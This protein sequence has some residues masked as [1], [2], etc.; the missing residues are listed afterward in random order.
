MLVGLLCGSER[1][2]PPAFIDRVNELG[3][4][5]GIH[6]EMLALGGTWIGEPP[7]YSV[8]ID[9]ISQKIAYYR[10][11]LK[12]ALLQGTYVINN[13]FWSTA[14]DRF[15]DS[16]IAQKLGL[17]VPRTVLLPQKSYPHDAGIGL[18]WDTLLEYVGRPALL[19]TCS[20]AGWDHTFKVHNLEELL[21][22]YDITG[23]YCVML[24]EFIDYEK[25][26]RCF[27]FGK[28]E[29]IP[30]AYDPATRQNQVIHDYLD[31]Q[32]GA[33]VVK[34]AQTINEA[35][36]YEM[37]SIDFAIKDGIPYA[38]DLANA[39]PE[40]ERER[41]TEF[42]FTHIVDRMARLVIDR[43]LNGSIANTWPRWREMAGLEETGDNTAPPASHAATSA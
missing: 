31:S 25:Y 27:T 2:F 6:A 3:K 4:K 43:A 21:A 42:Y 37:N 14:D 40:F 19:K 15:F 10:N 22:A 38:V 32:L 13:P 28:A 33:R 30:V 39:V 1:S 17:S 11:H 29:I 20:G 7:R 18:D 5:D 34:D 12:H 8:I 36:G 16:A 26:V 35:L 24:Q 9:R 41:I 23:P